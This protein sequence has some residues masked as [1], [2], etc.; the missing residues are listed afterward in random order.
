MNDE[1]TPDGMLD[2][3]SNHFLSRLIDVGGTLRRGY[4]GQIHTR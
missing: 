2:Q 3:E 4:G 1:V